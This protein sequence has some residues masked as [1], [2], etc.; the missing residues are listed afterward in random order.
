MIYAFLKGALRYQR[1]TR[2]KIRNPD[3][4]F[5]RFLMEFLNYF[6]RDR[7]YFLGIFFTQCFL[8]RSSRTPNTI[9]DSHLFCIIFFHFDTKIFV[10]Y[11][12]IFGCFCTNFLHQ[13]FFFYTKIFG[14]FCTNFLHQK[15]CFLH[16]N[17]WLFLH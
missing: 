10:F 1:V 5:V 14:C 7:F 13:N 16:E 12:K 11:T 15:F 4:N 3:E 2:I 8:H 9:L 6:L 17:F